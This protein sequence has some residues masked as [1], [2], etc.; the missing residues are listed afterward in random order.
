MGLEQHRQV[1][2]QH[3]SQGAGLSWIPG[4]YMVRKNPLLRCRLPSD[5]QCVLWHSCTCMHAHR[6]TYTE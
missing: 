4:T 2:G 6:C 3:G 5:L 1:L